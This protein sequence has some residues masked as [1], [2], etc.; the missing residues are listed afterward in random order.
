MLFCL[1]F[2]EPK[3]ERSCGEKRELAI[4]PAKPETRLDCNRA[5]MLLAAC[6]IEW[7]ALTIAE[8]LAPFLMCHLVKLNL[9]FHVG[10]KVLNPFG[11]KS[12]GFE[13]LKVQNLQKTRKEFE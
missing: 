1:Y 10:T 7:S 13:P 6:I 5:Y 2:R 11:F 9:F 8:L 12:I 4:P 3:K